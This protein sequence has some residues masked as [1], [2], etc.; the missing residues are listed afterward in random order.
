VGFFKKA[1]FSK[2]GGLTDSELVYIL[3]S[4]FELKSHDVAFMV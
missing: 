4:P 1:G 2:K 3:I